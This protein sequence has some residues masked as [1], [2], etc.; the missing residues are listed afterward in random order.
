MIGKLILASGKP[1]LLWGRS[2]LYSCCHAPIFSLASARLWK[3]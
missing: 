2:L 3:L 1:K